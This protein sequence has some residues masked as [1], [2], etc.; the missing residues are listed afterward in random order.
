MRF[1][2]FESGVEEWLWSLLCYK[3]MVVV[4]HEVIDFESGVIPLVD[5]RYSCCWR[6]KHIWLCHAHVAAVVTFLILNAARRHIRD[7]TTRFA[8]LLRL[9]SLSLCSRGSTT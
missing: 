5:H 6:W 7:E 4:S 9:I 3:A 8:D 2:W 1:G